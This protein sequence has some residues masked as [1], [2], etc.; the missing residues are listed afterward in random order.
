MG[1]STRHMP[2][3]ETITARV[4]T[5]K[6]TPEFMAAVER[7]LT[8]VKTLGEDHPVTL[9]AMILAM[10]LAPEELKQEMD[11]LAEELNLIPKPS[12]YLEDGEP[13]FLLHDIAQHHG[14]T[15]E[16]AEERLRQMLEDRA[17]L[18]L[19]SGVVTDKTKVYRR[20]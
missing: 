15:T 18:G 5:M 17:A 4:I 7:H 20:H 19:P 6:T 12:G 2:H 10:H 1:A 9:R 8:L 11:S 13:M 14:W 16:Q 3:R